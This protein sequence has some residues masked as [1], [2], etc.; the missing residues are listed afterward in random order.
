MK[1]FIIQKLFANQS[2]RQYITVAIPDNG[3]LE[4][5]FLD[6]AGI[7]IDVSAVQFVLSQVPFVIGIWIPKGFVL[8]K[9]H[10]RLTIQGSEGANLVT[11]DL[12]RQRVFDLERGNFVLFTVVTSRFAFVHWLRQKLIVAYF[13]SRKKH[14]ATFR[15]LDNFSATYLFPR[16][17]VLTCC[18]KNDSYNIFPMDLQG[19]IPEANICVLGLRNTNISLGI[20]LRERKLLVCEVG[21]RHKDAILSLGQHHSSRPPTPDGL[22]FAFEHS[23]VFDILVPSIAHG[24]RELELLDHLNMGTH[25]LM[26]ARVVNELQR[27]ESSS[28]YHLH[29]LYAIKRRVDYQ[30]A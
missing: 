26:L 14:H 8:P 3:I 25:T 21:A 7:R 30:I 23:T 29:T 18:G 20:I 5:A 15:E 9:K 27:Q 12:N 4:K 28:L 13:F 1:R 2:A 19:F 22:P 16:K 10:G 17:V 6:Y 24:Y 11:I